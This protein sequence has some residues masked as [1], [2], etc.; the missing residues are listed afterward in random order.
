[1][2]SNKS[3]NNT[4]YD[5]FFLE[6]TFNA[7]EMLEFS[8]TE[9]EWLVSELKFKKSAE[10]LDVACGSGRHLKAFVDLGYR[11][12]GLDRSPDCIKLAKQNC[13]SIADQIIEDDFLNFVMNKPSNYDLV[14]IAGASFGY[15]PSLRVNLDYLKSLM[16]IVLP[17]G[18]LVIQFLNKTW[19]D[20]Y[21]KNKLTFWSENNEFYTLDKRTFTGELLYSEKIFIKKDDSL[22]KKYGD[23]IYTFTEAELTD[24]VHATAS[25]I[26]KSFKVQK[27]SDS[28]SSKKFNEKSS[29]TPVLILQRTP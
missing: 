18:H 8:K 27:I 17:G 12:S 4:I 5:S 1:M 20:S 29:A 6:K 23:V 15:D 19:A 11:P 7:P 28:L 22:Q 21:I 2:L 16:K 14:F 10:I 26:K 24:Y 13:P 9:I 3:V 25:Q